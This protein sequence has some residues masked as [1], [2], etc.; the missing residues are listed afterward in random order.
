MSTKKELEDLLNQYLTVECE[1]RGS[2]F[3]ELLDEFEEEYEVTVLDLEISVKV[4]KV[5]IQKTPSISEIG[6]KNIEHFVHLQEQYLN[7]EQ[8][9]SLSELQC[10]LL[11]KKQLANGGCSMFEEEFPEYITAKGVYWDTD[12]KTSLQSFYSELLLID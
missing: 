6:K 11:E 5:K 1:A 10:R 9:P 3:G 12:L 7:E 4:K 8:Y 2:V